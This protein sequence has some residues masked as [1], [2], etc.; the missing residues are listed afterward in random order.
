M[1]LNTLTLILLLNS[2]ITVGLILTQN[3]S[4][5]DN[6]SSTVSTELS[7]PLQTLTW[8]CVLLEFAL[9][10]LKTKITEF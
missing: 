2:F 4:T 8:F 6:I 5:K 7:N 10:L 9:F 1:I 3:E